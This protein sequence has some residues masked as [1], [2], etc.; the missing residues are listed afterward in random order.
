MP[1]SKRP[2]EEQEKTYN[3]AADHYDLPPLSFWDRF[4]QRTVDRLPL[5]TGMA[6]LDV[7]CG[8]GASAIPGDLPSVIPA[9]SSPVSVSCHF[10]GHSSRGR[11]QPPLPSGFA[12]KGL[13]QR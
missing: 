11:P 5:L 3:A 12:S 10:L 9:L 6:V 1:G 2:Q 4:G 7:C 8:V 13:Q